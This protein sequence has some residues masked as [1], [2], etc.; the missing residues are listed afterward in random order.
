MKIERELKKLNKSLQI[1]TN[2]LNKLSNILFDIAREKG[3]VFREVVN[4][5]IKNEKST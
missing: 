2:N 4:N 1:S 5:S 3:Q